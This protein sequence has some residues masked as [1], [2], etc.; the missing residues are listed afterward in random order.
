MLHVSMDLLK[1]NLKDSK[2]ID[3]HIMVKIL[4]RMLEVLSNEGPE[5][6]F[7]ALRDKIFKK[8]KK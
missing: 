8:K 1:K 6:P 4:E 7:D 2:I 3:E 5:V